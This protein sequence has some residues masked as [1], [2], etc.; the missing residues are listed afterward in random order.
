MHLIHHQQVSGQ[1]RRPHMGVPHLQ[2]PHHRLVHGADGDLGGEE[3]L[4]GLGGPDSPPGGVTRVVLPPDF[5]GAQVLAGEV[6]G[7]EVT[8]NCQDRIGFI[9]GGEQIGYKL[10]DPP[11]QLGCRG[12]GGQRK[13]KPIHQPSLVHAGE[14]PQHGLR[15]AGAGFGLDDY[16]GLIQ[17]RFQCGL[18][19]DGVGRRA[20]WYVEQSLETWDCVNRAPLFGQV[21][22][23]ILDCAARLHPRRIHV[24]VIGNIHELEPVLVG[25]NPVGQG[26]QAQKHVLEGGSVGERRRV[27]R[28]RITE[29][30]AHLMADAPNGLLGVQ[31]GEG[32]PD[33]RIGLFGVVEVQGFAV[34]GTRGGK[35][36]G[37][38]VSIIGV[39]AQQL[40]PPQ[41]IQEPVA[42]PLVITKQDR[43]QVRR[44]AGPLRPAPPLQVGVGPDPRLEADVDLADVVEAG[45]HAQAGYGYRIQVVASG[46]AGQPLANG[47]LPQQPLEASADIGQV[48][49]KQVDT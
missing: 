38:G 10:V 47:R 40:I 46:S 16:H 15:L 48:M 29:P 36:C 22:P 18:L 11:V 39:P 32:L 14:P 6:P 24:I 45:E 44:V 9:P 37:N 28:P 20:A 35:Q 23:D 33:V 13:V 1:A 43:R 31:A 17:G 2:R 25:A 27:R 49:L 42:G 8:R 5:I 7:P 19:L 4:G 26:T 12:A 34:V 41:R 30:L 21:Q 3:P